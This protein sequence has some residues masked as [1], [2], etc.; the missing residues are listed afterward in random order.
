MKEY[1]GPCG[2][3]AKIIEDSI[4]F[5]TRLLTVELR[6][7]RF[8]HS[9]LMT[10]RV[11]SRNASSSRA[12]P[13]S[14]ML[15]QVCSDPAMPVYWGSNK[16]GMQAGDEVNSAQLKNVKKYWEDA[17]IQAVKHAEL[18]S[19]HGLHKQI[20]NRLLE[21]WQ[22]MKTIVT[23]TEWDNFF[24]LRLHPDAQ[25]E[26]RALAECIKVVYETNIPDVK[27]AGKD[28]HLPYVSKDEKNIC[29]I[30]DLIK[31][32][33][34]RCARVSYLNHDKSSPD[35]QKDLLLHDKLKESGHMSPFEHI[36][37][38]MDSIEAT[39]WLNVDGIT[40]IDK[41]LVKWSGNFRNWIQYR[42]LL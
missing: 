5:G 1:M 34:A 29:D 33:V 20:A 19:E 23:A 4:T 32:S 28:W 30:N 12:I 24:E 42:Q 39:D 10:H 11:F 9:E 2:I 25:P 36:A 21:P 14:K 38:P 17:S 3:S 31:L 40:H 18:L 27:L 35:H 37:T 15:N 16:P 8:I 26:F 7:P 6:Y 13:V 22:F 41:Q